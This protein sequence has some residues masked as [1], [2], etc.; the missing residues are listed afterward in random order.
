MTYFFPSTRIRL[1][2]RSTCKHV[3]PLVSIFIRPSVLISSSTTNKRPR[4]SSDSCSR[5]C[6]HFLI[7]LCGQH[8][9][10]KWIKFRKNDKS[11]DGEALQQFYERRYGVHAPSLLARSTICDQHTRFCTWRL[12]SYLW[13]QCRH[14]LR[15]NDK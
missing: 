1:K 8:T 2:A 5:Y 12:W 15:S 13:C 3:L 14:Y 11:Y 4:L 6:I 7:L 10:E 9:R